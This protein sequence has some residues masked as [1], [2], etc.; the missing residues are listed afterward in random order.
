MT[1]QEIEKQ[2]NLLI[3][4]IKDQQNSVFIL[5][6][7]VEDIYRI[8]TK[9]Q[10]FNISEHLSLDLADGEQNQRREEMIQLLESIKEHLDIFIKGHEV[11]ETKRKPMG[12]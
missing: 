2:I 6:P 9:N 7:L 5:Q 10:D 12:F 1:K 3:K 8:V 11:N 4:R